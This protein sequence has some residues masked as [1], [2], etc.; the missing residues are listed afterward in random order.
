MSTGALTS[1]CHVNGHS[2]V[3]LACRRAHLLVYT[4]I[5]ILPFQPTFHRGASLWHVDGRAYVVLECQR[6]QLRRFVMSTGIVMSFWHVHRYLLHISLLFSLSNLL[7]GI[8]GDVV[9]ACR[10]GHLLAIAAYQLAM[11]MG[12]DTFLT[13]FLTLHQRLLMNTS[14]HPCHTKAKA[15]TTSTTSRDW[16]HLPDLSHFFLLP[17][18]L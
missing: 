7:F 6:A 15:A 14:L 4:L 3:V 12:R 5:T 18:G 17:E 2:Y 13:T 9:L 1:F 16:S 8:A 10:R 11:S